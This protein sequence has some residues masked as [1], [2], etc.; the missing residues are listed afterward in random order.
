MK[1]KC[2]ML[3][4][5]IKAWEVMEA[6]RSVVNCNHVKG[7]QHC[8]QVFEVVCL[9]VDHVIGCHMLTRSSGH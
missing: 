7:F 2:K 9:P 5:P 8:V 3:V 6:W 1:A 4:H